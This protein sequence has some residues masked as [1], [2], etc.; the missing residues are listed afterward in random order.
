ML[1]EVQKAALKNCPTPKDA[2]KMALWALKNL[3]KRIKAAEKVIK[4]HR[5]RIADPKTHM[6]RDDPT[7]ELKRRAI[8]DWTKHITRQEGILKVLGKAVEM[9][10]AVVRKVCPKALWP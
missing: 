4:E 10:K 5:E 1:A 9:A 7:P 6:L 2:C 8:R 3:R